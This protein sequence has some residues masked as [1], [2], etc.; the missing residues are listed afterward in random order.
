MREV[1]VR[2]AENPERDGL[3][4]TPERVERSMRYLTSGYQANAGDTLRGGML[5]VAYD[6]MVLMK[7]IEMLSLCE[8]H[9]LPFFG[10]VHIAYIPRIKLIDLTTAPCLVDIL[11]RRL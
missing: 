7:G 8:H 6:E 1:L 11:A 9:L 5:D 10:K 2:L 3:R 4:R